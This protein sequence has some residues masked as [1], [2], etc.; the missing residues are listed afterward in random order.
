MKLKFT[1][2]KSANR[3]CGIY[4]YHASY[5]YSKTVRKYHP[6]VPAVVSPSSAVVT[7]SAVVS[8]SSAVVT[9]SAVVLP[10]YVR[11]WNVIVKF[12]KNLF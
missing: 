1:E 8:P 2:Q 10:W 3:F 6:Y 5:D 9:S 12:F 7:S 11:L 4:F